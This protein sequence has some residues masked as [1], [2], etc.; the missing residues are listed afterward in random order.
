MTS[1]SSPWKYAPSF[2]QK[3]FLCLPLQCLL[4]KASFDCSVPVIAMLI[5]QVFSCFA[6]SFE[7]VTH[8]S[9]G[10]DALWFTCSSFLQTYPWDV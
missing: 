10:L 4:S 7:K 1:S 8:S 9:I 5:L 3:Y 6:R 2:Q